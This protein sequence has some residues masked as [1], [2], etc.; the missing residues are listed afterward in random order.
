MNKPRET[1][2]I[3]NVYAAPPLYKCE[4]LDVEK[5]NTRYEIRKIHASL[6]KKFLIWNKLQNAVFNDYYK[7]KHSYFDLI[8]I[9]T[10][11]RIKNNPALKNISIFDLFAVI[12]LEILENEKN[13]VNL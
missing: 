13:V 8:F 10:R 5:W 7:I 3:C 4:M 2:L 9:Q 1:E 11:I 6:L 12:L